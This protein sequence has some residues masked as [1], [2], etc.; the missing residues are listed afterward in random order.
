[1]G[2]YVTKHRCVNGILK[3]KIVE[4]ASLRTVEWVHSVVISRGEVT[5]NETSP[6]SER[7]ID[8]ILNVSLHVY[9]MDHNSIEQ[10][11][12][13]P[14][15]DMIYVLFTF[16]FYKTHKW[17]KDMIV[18]DIDQVPCDKYEWLNCIMVMEVLSIIK[19]FPHVFS[20]SWLVKVTKLYEKHVLI[21]LCLWNDVFLQ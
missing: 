5:V 3:K 13:V 10:M 8:P 7:Y 20:I 11:R 4:N 19:C 9:C 16:T 15:L 18:F 17:K 14:P 12:W 6:T 1:M 2:K 21:L